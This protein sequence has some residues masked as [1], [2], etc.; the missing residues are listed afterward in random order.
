MNEQPKNQL[1]I[2][3]GETDISPSRPSLLCGYCYDRLSTGIHDR[4]YA[5]S[6]ALSDGQIPM[7]LCVLDVISVHDDVVAETRRRVQKECGL[8]PE[9]FILAAIHTHT[10]PDL[11][12]EPEYAAT[13]PG[14]VAECVRL[15]LSDM[16]PRTLSVACRPVNGLSFI[17]R[18]RMKD[19]S[20]RTNPGIGNP[21]ILEPIGIVD[22]DLRVLMALENGRPVGGLVHF[23]LHCDTVGG[24]EVSA[25]WSHY[26]RRGMQQELGNHW[27]LLT[28]VG[29]CGDV[30]HWNVFSDVSL[31]GF[32]ETE[33]IGSAMARAALSALKHAT[34]VHAAGSIHA[35]ARTVS[36]KTRM[37][38]P[39]DLDAAQQLMSKP[40]LEKLDFTMDRVQARQ[41]IR[42]AKLGPSL[43]VDITVLAFGNVAL[44][45]MPAECFTELGRDIKRRSPFAHTLVC[46][47][48]NGSVGYVPAQAN[49][50]EGGY[51]A[52]SCILAPGAGEKMADVAVELLQTTFSRIKTT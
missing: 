13:I 48:A 33:R 18:Y 24:T 7:V 20:V 25:D 51:E 46:T 19:G 8:S 26:L 6:M 47:L 35:E 36:L 10:A 32:A 15:A 12:R 37:P 42:T 34:I 29:P 9:R 11:Q 5:R 16:A 21:D 23:A 17:R 30:N 43:C 41:K 27:R 52:A 2:G 39:A 14:S 45:G 1:Q 28:P 31:R 44:V 4:L 22:P 50:A 3:F 40:T 49:F 38:S